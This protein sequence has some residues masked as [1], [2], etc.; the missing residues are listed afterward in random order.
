MVTTVTPTD[1]SG[2]L[3][4]RK[5]EMEAVVTDRGR[6]E[7]KWR[8]LLDSL[9]PAGEH[10]LDLTAVSRP[11]AKI[12]DYQLWCNRFFTGVAY[13]YLILEEKEKQANVTHHGLGQLSILIIV[14]FHVVCRQKITGD[15]QRQLL[16]RVT[17][18]LIL[19]KMT[20]IKSMFSLLQRQYLMS[21]H[22]FEVLLREIIF[23]IKHYG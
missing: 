8:C 5:S 13:S 6:T 16:M 12:I 7:S 19:L 23:I 20:I 10:I 18:S 3:W 22:Y 2:G 21:S 17:L 1:W 11:N 9:R 4:Q 15:Q 14:T